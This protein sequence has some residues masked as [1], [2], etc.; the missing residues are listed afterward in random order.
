MLVKFSENTIRMQCKTLEGR[1]P[2]DSTGH[3]KENIA[4]NYQLRLPVARIGNK[5]KLTSNDQNA[6]DSNLDSVSESESDVRAF[7][8]SGEHSGSEI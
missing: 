1:V 2:R 3:G 4:T 5:K 7:V 8:H 6:H